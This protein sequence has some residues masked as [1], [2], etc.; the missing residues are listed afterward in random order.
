LRAS[1][2]LVKWDNNILEKDDMLISERYSET[3]NNRSQDIKK[4][5][6]SVELMRFVNQAEKALVNSL[7]D[8]FSTGYQLKFK[9]KQVIN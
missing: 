1:L 4:L 7:S 5:S 3:G 2:D 9:A 8:H 6:G